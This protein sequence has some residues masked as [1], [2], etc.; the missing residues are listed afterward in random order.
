MAQTTTK[1]TMK[2]CKVEMS[3]NGSS[4][5]DISGYSNAIAWEGGERQTE[6]VH[7]F[8]GD[9][10][11]IGGA[12]RDALSIT[13]KVVYTEGGTDAAIAAQSAYE[14][15]TDF[16][17]RWSPRGATSGQKLYTSSA[18]IVKNPVLPAGEASSA[19]PILVDI[20]LE[21]A[22]ITPSTVTP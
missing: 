22:S 16:Y 19:T 20:V 5:T 13:A 11:L 12:K 3:T 1:Y 14:N 7:T 8:D 4:W 21:V 6:S 15:M 18:G 10:P 2:N 17:L 9:M